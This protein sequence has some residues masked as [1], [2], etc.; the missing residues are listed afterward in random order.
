MR[1][2]GSVAAGDGLPIDGHASM[3]LET[4]SRFALT[5]WGSGGLGSNSLGVLGEVNSFLAL[6]SGAYVSVVWVFW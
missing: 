6:L 1:L 5:V 4:S 2:K 3:S